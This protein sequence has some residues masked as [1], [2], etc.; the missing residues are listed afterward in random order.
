ML[1][2][3]HCL[4]FL[5]II[6]ESRGAYV[7]GQVEKPEADLEREVRALHVAL[8]SLCRKRETLPN[9][10][11]Y[12]REFVIRAPFNLSTLRALPTGA[13][14]WSVNT[15]TLSELTGMTEQR[16]SEL[17]HADSKLMTPS[18]E[19]WVF[20]SAIFDRL[21]T[22]ASGHT[23]GSTEHSI[24]YVEPG[25]QVLIIHP[26]TGLDIPKLAASLTPQFDDG[27]WRN[28]IPALRFGPSNRGV[29]LFREG[30]DAAV[31]L[32]G[33]SHHDWSDAV[34]ALDTG[35]PGSYYSKGGRVTAEEAAWVPVEA[36]YRTRY[37]SILIRHIGAIYALPHMGIHVYSKSPGIV[38]EIFQHERSSEAEYGFV[39]AME[40]AS[41]VLIR[42]HATPDEIAFT[43]QH[44]DE[45]GPLLVR[46]A[47]RPLV[48]PG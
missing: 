19:Q 45:E 13:T 5:R 39:R 34:R 35:T 37:G 31:I 42:S 17:L 44:Q 38:L 10:L 47:L 23:P 15:E 3:E 12:E 26:G 1:V 20:E 40:R 28:G 30:I 6:R 8:P 25:Q 27:T 9:L 4:I 7:I 29:V 36:R 48:F 24:Q 11:V 14:I 32:A 41:L 43:F 21:W 22:I 2:N 33:V 18:T 46:L 16:A